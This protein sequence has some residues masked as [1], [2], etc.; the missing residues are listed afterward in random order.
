MFDKQFYQT[1]QNN[2]EIQSKMQL[3]K[4]T[5]EIITGYLL[6]HQNLLSQRSNYDKEYG[7]SQ[8]ITKS[9][10]TTLLELKDWMEDFENSRCN[11]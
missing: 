7:E 1:I 6:K 2:P 10:N 3:I 4:I 8:E 5:P 9:K 11:C